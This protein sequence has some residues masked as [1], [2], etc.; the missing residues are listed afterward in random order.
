MSRASP[1]EFVEGRFLCEDDIH[2]GT[3]LEESLESTVPFLVFG[4]EFVSCD[5]DW[6]CNMQ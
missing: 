2:I 5:V 4:V 3:A 6:C 1:A